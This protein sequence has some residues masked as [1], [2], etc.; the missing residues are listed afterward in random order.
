MKVL[1]LLALLFHY[2]LPAL[3][4]FQALLLQVVLVE[5]MSLTRMTLMALQCCIR[6]GEALLVLMIQKPPSIVL[7]SRW[8][9]WQIRAFACELRFLR[10]QKFQKMRLEQQ[11]SGASEDVVTQQ[12]QENVC[13]VSVA[14]MVAWRCQLQL[15]E[16]FA[17]LKPALLQNWPR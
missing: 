1:T 6:S 11:P 13:F 15:L 5:K 10:L 3:C 9:Q 16:V 7:A 12:A 17:S 8:A 14:V 2:L 4:F